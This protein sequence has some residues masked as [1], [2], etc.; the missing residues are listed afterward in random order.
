M[1]K[2]LTAALLCALAALPLAAE[3]KTTPSG[4]SGVINAPSGYVRLP[5]HVS[6]GLDWTKEGR[7]VRGN[8]ALPLGLEIAGQPCGYQ[9]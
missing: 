5:G 9:T 8:I 1:K 7:N 4:T 3:A 6:G 2:Q